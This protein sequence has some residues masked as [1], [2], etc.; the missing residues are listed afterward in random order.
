MNG[1]QDC[2]HI[3]S[4]M[5][6][7]LS[8]TPTSIPLVVPGVHANEKS[9]Q[10]F[11]R[12]EG[13][14]NCRRPRAKSRNK[15][16]TKASTVHGRRWDREFRQTHL[17]LTW[18]YLFSTIISA[19]HPPTKLFFKQI[20]TNALY[21]EWKRR[22]NTI[23]SFHSQSHTTMPEIRNKGIP[24]EL[25]TSSNLVPDLEIKQP[26]ACDPRQP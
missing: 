1:T 20:R 24:E 23:S 19:A 3:S 18:A 6:R 5:R 17:Q 15:H 4:R 2:H 8:A 12:T 21:S 26:C 13:N 7:K 16:T 25:M 9:D 10:N 14:T 22:K 11:G